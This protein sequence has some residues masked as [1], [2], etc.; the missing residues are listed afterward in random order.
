MKMMMTLIKTAVTSTIMLITLFCGVIAGFV[1]AGVLSYFINNYFMSNPKPFEELLEEAREA[2]HNVDAGGCADLPAEAAS[3]IRY[4]KQNATHY[5]PGDELAEYAPNMKKLEDAL[6][7]QNARLWIVRESTIYGLPPPV[8]IEIP[9]HVVIRFGTHTSYIHLLIFPTG[10]HL[11]RLPKY[12][13]NIR[14]S[15]YLSR[16]NL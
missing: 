3:L 9:E 6:L 10:T 8:G 16:G 11:T 15:V 1:L 4:A 13:V 2:I 5:L 14:E 12:V 7:P